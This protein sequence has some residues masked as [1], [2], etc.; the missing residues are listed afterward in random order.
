MKK[1]ISILILIVTFTTSL[2]SQQDAEGCKDSPM[3]PKRMPNYFI[4]E[5]KSNY[6]EAD[7]KI[8]ADG[9][10]NEHREGTLTKVRYD[11][12]A[13]SG[14]QKPS[15]LQILKNYENASKSIGGVMV[16]Q[17]SADGYGTYKIMKNNKETAWIKV[18]CGGNDNTDF[19]ELTIIQLEEMK[20]DVTSA[21]ILTALKTD[22]HIA[23]YINFETGKADI[24][25]ESQK[26]IDQIADMLKANATLKISIEGHTDNAGTPA[27]NQ[28][29]SENRAK[30]VMNALITGG[31][32]KNRLT[33]KGWGQTKPLTENNTEESKAKNRRVEIVKP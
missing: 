19:Y 18:E 1:T 28:T 14:Q 33:A 13:E 7:F 5:C 20:Q 29:L 24:K 2:F 23:L 10:K 15:V 27:S 4:S 12:N 22:G 30:S 21:D 26:I 31:I 32:D 8:T 16:L 25:A 17:T 3:F 11:F 9:R 6:G